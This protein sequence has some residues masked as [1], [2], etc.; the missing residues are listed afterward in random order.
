MA[1][2]AGRLIAIFAGFPLTGV[3]LL[4]FR[5]FS[6]RA[7]LRLTALEI[8]AERCGQPGFFPDVCRIGL[9]IHKVPL[10]RPEIGFKALLAGAEPLWQT[11]PARCDPP[12]DLT[13]VCCRS[14]VVE[15]LIGNE[16]V[17]SSI[18]CGSTIT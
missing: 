15:H 6:P 14:S 4:V 8:F 10:S 17:H 7:N 3:L 1:A 11:L 18:L 12:R 16:E 13:P 5:F 2:R 9:F